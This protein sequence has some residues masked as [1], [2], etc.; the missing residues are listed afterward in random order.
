MLHY[1]FTCW[2]RRHLYPQHKEQDKPK[3]LL[4]VE[5]CC[6]RR[7]ANH[8][9]FQSIITFSLTQL[10]HSKTTFPWIQPILC[11]YLASFLSFLLLMPTQC[12]VDP[13]LLFVPL[14]GTDINQ[15]LIELGSFHI[16]CHWTSLVIGLC[17]LSQLEENK[18]K[19]NNTTTTNNNKGNRTFI[20]ELFCN[21]NMKAP[22]NPRGCSNHPYFYLDWG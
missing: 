18:E 12:V 1:Y 22:K 19:N 8:L 5:S 3:S 16:W 13:F 11:T 2:Q 6:L 9:I 17:F 20:S 4:Y 15:W 14:S 10:C 7:S 21:P